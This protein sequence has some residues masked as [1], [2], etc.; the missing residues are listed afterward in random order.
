MGNC[1]FNLK[2]VKITWQLYMAL[3]VSRKMR[4]QKCYFTCTQLGDYRCRRMKILY[5]GGVGGGRKVQ[6]MGVRIG[7]REGNHELSRM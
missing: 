2:N 1:I 6:V 4:F 7:D 5:G 3:F